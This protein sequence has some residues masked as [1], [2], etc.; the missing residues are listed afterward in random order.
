MRELIC[1]N[2][3]AIK[4]SKILRVQWDEQHDDFI[5]DLKGIFDQA[6]DLSPAKGNILKILASFFY[7]L[8]HLQ[9]VLLHCK[10]LF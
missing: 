9:P 5:Y 10:L 7:P 8:G 1:D 2:D 6:K 3:T 4:P